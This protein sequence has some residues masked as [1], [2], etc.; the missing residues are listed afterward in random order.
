MASRADAFVYWTNQ[1]ATSSAKGTPP[2]MTVKLKLTK[3]GNSKLTGKGKL[4]T[5]A[6]VTFTPDGGTAKA[7]TAEIKIKGKSKKP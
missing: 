1:G 6:R 3:L 4:K 2:T 7:Q 5:K